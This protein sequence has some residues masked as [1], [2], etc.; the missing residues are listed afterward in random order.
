MLKPPGMQVV[1]SGISLWE[2]FQQGDREAFALLYRQHV[3]DLYHYG[4]HF[5][6]DGERVKDCLQDL[7]QDLWQSREHLS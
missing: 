1:T 5:C 4:M 2:R 6:T 3:D 7:F